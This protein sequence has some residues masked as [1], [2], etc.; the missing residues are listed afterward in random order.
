L[1][2][3]LRL[4]ILHMERS[5]VLITK[6]VIGGIQQIGVGIPDMEAAW[7][8]YRKYYGLNVRIFQEA[9]EAPLML[10]YTGGEVHSR[11]A[12]YAINI[13][14]G[15][16]LEIW[17]FTSRKTEPPSFKVQLGDYGIYAA[18]IKSRDIVATLAE[19]QTLGLTTKSEL[20]KDPAGRE[21]F[22]AT[23]PYGNLFQIVAGE[24]WLT[25]GK[26]TTGGVCGCLL[27][28][29]DID[30]SR[31]L[32]S[33]VLG[34]DHV[35]YDESGVFEDFKG[36]PGG[37]GKFRRVLLSHSEPHQGLFSRLLGKTWIELVQSLDRKPVK[38]YKD[39]F[40]GDAGFI[41]LCFDVAGM[42]FLEKECADAGFPFTVNSKNSFDMGD[43]AGQFS[44]IEDPDGTLIEFI[45]T[46]KV[47][48]LRKI[49]W[50]LDLSKKNPEKPLPDWMV[51]TLRFNKVK[52]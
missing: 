43:A 22:T 23:D 46:H 51:K 15:G 50:Y 18:K 11:N 33:G 34:Y 52:D 41:H 45:E 37:E 14:G 6:K 29:S 24:D 5:L 28:V 27:G 13:Q 4:T 8:W 19:F 40:W 35:I 3:S 16:G 25:S 31:S 9:A 20:L 7:A 39:R 32:Y 44:Y 12:T 48:L 42:N 2:D 1:R 10:D 36:L 26:R 21:Y 49:G 38:I 47:P 17:Q 30:K